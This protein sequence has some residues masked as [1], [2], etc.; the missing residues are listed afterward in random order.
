MRL[1]DEPIATILEKMRAKAAT[2]RR[3]TYD[4]FNAI[5]KSDRVVC[6]L[7]IKLHPLRGSMPL[8]SVLA[9]RG[10]LVC[11]KCRFYEEEE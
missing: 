4:C 10:A 2:K 5:C 6:K 9:G 8:L 1:Y 11:K 7:G 3:I